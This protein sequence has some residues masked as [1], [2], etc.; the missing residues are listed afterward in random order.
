LIHADAKRLAKAITEVPLKGKNKIKEKTANAR[1]RLNILTMQLKW[2]KIYTNTNKP[3]VDDPEV[4]PFSKKIVKNLYISS[5]VILPTHT[6]SR[7]INVGKPLTCC[8]V[9]CQP[10]R[11]A[12]SSNH[13]APRR[14]T[15]N[16]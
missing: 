10:D 16:D 4:Y 12:H 8:R 11:N 3:N 6:D 5:E 13:Q 14:N 9:F 7:K 1:N 2:I 15:S